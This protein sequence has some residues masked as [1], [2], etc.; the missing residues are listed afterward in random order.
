MN[1]FSKCEK[2]ELADIYKIE[3]QFSIT[4]PKEFIAHYLR[5]NG[6]VPEK[7]WWE[8]DDEYEP[9]E[10]TCFKP[11]VYNSQTHD[12]PSSLVEGC[13]ISMLERDVI[14]IKLLPFANDWGG[15]F[16]CL[17]LEDYSIIYYAND[18][19]D[20]SLT[21]QENHQRLQRKLTNTFENFVNGLVKEEDLS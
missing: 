9:I 15:N 8:S 11:F 6:G 13:Y 19:F 7:S 16:F 5:F 20:E 4:L 14:P 3:E 21:M 1:N 10:V 18:S 2:I 12:E 17:D